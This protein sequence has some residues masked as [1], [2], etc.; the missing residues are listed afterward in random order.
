MKTIKIF[1][2]TALFFICVF[3]GMSAISA[4]NT[5]KFAHMTDVHL[6]DMKIDTGARVLT[7]S[8]ALF[9]D[10]L[11]QIKAE[12][13]LDFVFVTGDMTNSP[14]I[15]MIELFDTKMNTLNVPW[16]SAFGNH[17]ISVRGEISKKKY[18]EILRKNNKNYKFDKSYYSFVPKKGFRVIAL[19]SIIDDEIT[20]NGKL[21][22]EELKWLDCELLKA[23]KNGEIPLMFL[24]NPLYPPFSS[25]GIFTTRFNHELRNPDEFYA[26]LKK[27]NMPMAIFSGHYHMTKIYKEGN[28]LHVSTPSMVCYPNA[29]RFVT[30]TNLK[31]KVIFKLDWK[32]TGLK[33]I[34]AKAK[35]LIINPKR[36]EGQYS[37][38]EAVIV[39]D[40]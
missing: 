25:S 19:D 12:P 22:H 9:D 24:H 8:I 10:E 36:Y 27:Y 15:P 13:N 31:D 20:C 11:K 32:E 3:G 18:I 37:D 35:K 17:D 34:Q 29:F 1:F 40:K 7:D 21:S 4:G 6:S 33:D 38:R 5:L 30:V 28:I 16:Y 26:V 14:N 39:I 2:I 23:H